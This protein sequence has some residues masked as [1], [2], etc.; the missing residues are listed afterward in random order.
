MADIKPT[1]SQQ[2]AQP[3]AQTAPSVKPKSFFSFF[4]F[5]KGAGS[6]LDINML[7]RGLIVIIAG[8]IVYFSAGFSRSWKELEKLSA[9]EFKVSLA[10]S[11]EAVFQEIPAMKGVSYYLSKVNGHDIFSR[12]SKEQELIEEPVFSSKMAD[13]TV[14]LKLVGISMS[15][16]PDAMIEDTKLQKTFFVKKGAKIGELEVDSITKDKVVLKFNKEIFELK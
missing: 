1:A 8:L 13:M 4:G 14:N 2:N 7:N 15:A 12:K 5:Q 6:Q 3:A 11:A 9:K 10:S 16:E